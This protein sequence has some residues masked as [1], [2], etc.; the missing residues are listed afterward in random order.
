MVVVAAGRE[1][2]RAQATDFGVRTRD[3]VFPQRHF[4]F[5]PKG[6][7]AQTA[8]KQLFVSASSAIKVYR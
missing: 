5:T 1:A 2:G 8:L 7:P 4:E 6:N 3:S